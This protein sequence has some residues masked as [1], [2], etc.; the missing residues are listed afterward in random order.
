VTD[1]AIKACIEAGATSIE[2]VARRCSAGSRC[3]GCWPVIEK[4]L[5]EHEQETHAGQ[6]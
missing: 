5:A 4:L 3:G 1:R 2:D 6:R